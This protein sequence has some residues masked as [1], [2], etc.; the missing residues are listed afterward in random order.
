MNVPLVVG[1]G[2]LIVV[3]TICLVVLSTKSTAN[4]KNVAAALSSLPLSSEWQCVPGINTPIRKNNEGLVQCLGKFW[5]APHYDITCPDCA[6]T[7]DIEQCKRLLDS[8]K[9]YS[10]TRLDL[11]AVTCDKPKYQTFQIDELNR[12]CPVAAQV[13]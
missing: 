3:G 7:E 6:W 5:F 1:I 9:G 10:P 12:L 2:V 11:T 13:L 8:T 4:S